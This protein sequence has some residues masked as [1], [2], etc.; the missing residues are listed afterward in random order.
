[1]WKIGHPSNRKL[2]LFIGDAFLLL[3]AAFLGALLR[4]ATPINVLD[5]YTGATLTFVFSFLL[6]FYVLDLYDVRRMADT[7]AMLLKITL[8]CGIAALI[9]STGFYFIPHYRYGRGV[10]LIA[11]LIMPLFAYGWRRSLR[12]YWSSVYRPI[13]TIIVGGGRRA[14]VIRDCLDQHHSSFQCL[15]VV[16]LEAEPAVE[17]DSGLTSLPVLGTLNALEELIARHEVG[18]LVI[19][20]EI[21]REFAETL[22]RLRFQGVSIYRD[23]EYAMRVSEHLPLDLL[24]DSWLWFAEGFDVQE[25]VVLRRMKRL[26]DLALAA[27]GLLVALPV[28]L[29]VA[30]AVKLDSPGPVFYRQ[31]RV[32]WLE[33]SFELIKFRTMVHDAEHKTSSL[34]T[35][36]D[37]PRVTRVGRI[38][39]SL[40]LDEIP[41]MTNILRGE[42]SFVGPRPERPE[43]VQELQRMIPYFYLRSYVPPGLTGWAQV[44][45]P[46]GASVDDS[47]RKL[48]FDLYYILHASPLFDFRI[49]LKTIQVII[50]R[51]GAR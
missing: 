41:Q 10:F 49:L 2:I 23:I 37:D 38:L 4:L 12:W 30:L 5:L 15:G 45:F 32:G 29:L 44:R 1:M 51:R 27:V 46:Y 3:L 50:Y 8:A 48:E 26:T 21:P 25:A 39:R 19:A 36:V 22:T 42:M 13:P 20:G 6:S 18:C 7:K 43:I 40:R 14:E 16:S 47:R 28:G 33:K 31:L 35:T 24:S 11:A 34:W 9:S 17:G